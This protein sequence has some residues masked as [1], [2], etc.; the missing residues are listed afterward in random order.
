[1]ARA[2]RELGAAVLYETAAVANYRDMTY[3]RDRIRPL[4]IRL[5]V[6]TLDRICLPVYTTI[7]G[8]KFRGKMVH[9]A[10]PV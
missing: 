10:T 3:R 4:R 2:E 9:V 6:L 8:E 1:M 5:I 7:A